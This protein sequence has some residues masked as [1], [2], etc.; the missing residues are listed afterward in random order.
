MTNSLAGI[1]TA[2]ESPFVAWSAAA[3][4]YGNKHCG[5]LLPKPQVKTEKQLKATCVDEP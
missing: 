4:G 5:L 3:Y 1:H 2:Q